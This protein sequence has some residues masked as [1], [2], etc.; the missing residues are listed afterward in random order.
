M[1]SNFLE[2]SYFFYFT[3]LLI[4]GLDS[5]DF[6]STSFGVGMYYYY[7]SGGFRCLTISKEDYSISFWS[8]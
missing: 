1:L 8:G 7:Y 5:F 4:S 6:D 2:I 3:D